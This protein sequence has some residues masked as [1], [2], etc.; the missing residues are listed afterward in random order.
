MSE[1]GIHPWLMKNLFGLNLDA[2][3]SKPRE[4][5]RVLE[6]ITSHPAVQQIINED[7]ER[8]LAERKALGAKILGAQDAQQARRAELEPQVKAA[9][10]ELRA[11]E[12]A[13]EA[14]AAK[15]RRLRDALHLLE[16]ECRAE[17]DR[18]ALLMEASPAPVIDETLAKLRILHDDIVHQQPS[19]VANKQAKNA[20]TGKVVTHLTWNRPA[21]IARGEA[22]RAAM[23]IATQAKLDHD[24]TDIRARMQ[25][26]IDDLPEVEY[27]TE[28]IG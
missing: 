2:I 4:L 19:T 22:I 28:E 16:H 6:R 23:R 3:A 26:L 1:N 12:P 10:R 11:L 24:H 21:L 14:A 5:E 20:R 18:L 9:Y 7:E 8:A 25:K 13:Y 17:N 15:W 27:V